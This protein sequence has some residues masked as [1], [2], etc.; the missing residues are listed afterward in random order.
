MALYRYRA[1][2]G[3]GL[4]QNGV[5]EAPDLDRA[6]E[7][8]HVLGL[9]P[10]RMESQSAAAL[11]ARRASP[12][13]KKVTTRDLILFTRQLETMLESGLPIL[14][15]LD[16]LHQQTAHAVLRE[17]IDRVRADVE[18]GSTLTEAMRR[19]P[20]CFPVVFVNLVHAGEEGG[21][22]TQMLDRIG[23]LLEYEEETEHRIRSATFYPT[24]IV[25]ELLLAF[26]VLVKFVLP[27]FASLFRGLGAELPLPTR[28]LIGTSDFF[29]K[30]WY[31]VIL[32]TI[33][34]ITAG[35]VWS[36]TEKGRRTLDAWILTA[37]I[38]GP[39][40]TKTIM[41]R[42]ARVLAALVAAGIPIV[43]ALGISRGVAGNKVVEEEIDRMRDGV[44]AGMGLSEPLRG[45]DV[46]PPIVIK[47]L[48]V[49]QETGAIDKMLL[50]VARYF[51]QDV[52]YTV[53]NL[54]SAIEPVLLAVLG[55]V[56][57]FTALA[58]FLPLWGLMDAFRH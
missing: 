32:M 5:V 27:R 14:S 1:L 23:G 55:A 6:L 48:A 46:F 39:I 53:K 41:S 54:S 24:L 44:I 30:Q 21:L 25:G 8:V 42:F 31:F 19:H 16:I 10:V 35:V 11:A 3:A 22:L 58:V 2:S 17:A 45:R 34:A 9:T 13:R 18:Q 33:A 36:R 28:I 7:A 20:R 56:V 49:G 57:L 51:D 26:V 52:D 47:M 38:F 40:F 43:Q 29:E 12:F 50:R 15:A 37:P 4:S